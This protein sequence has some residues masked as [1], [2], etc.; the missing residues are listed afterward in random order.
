MGGLGAR[1]SKRQNVRYRPDLL[2]PPGCRASGSC[3]CHIPFAGRRTALPAHL[4]APRWWGLFIC[5]AAPVF[6]SGGS[7]RSPQAIL[8]SRRT[9]GRVLRY[10]LR[11]LLP[12]ENGERILRPV[13]P[14]SCEGER[15]RLGKP[16][17]ASGL[18]PTHGRLKAAAT[19]YTASAFRLTRGGRPCACP[20]D[21]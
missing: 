11:P 8:K 1:R 13:R 14:Q 5:G 7:S 6:W 4:R 18:S 19:F 21:L 10:T 3:T 2:A 15:Q 12:R 17:V 20:F 9:R 16:D